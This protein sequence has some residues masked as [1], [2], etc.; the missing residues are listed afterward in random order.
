MSSR[1]Y[2]NLAGDALTVAFNTLGIQENHK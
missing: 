1:F 2:R